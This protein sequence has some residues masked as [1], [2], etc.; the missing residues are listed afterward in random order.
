MSRSIALWVCLAALLLPPMAAGA[1]G[2]EDEAGGWKVIAG[3][4][5]YADSD[6]IGSNETPECYGDTMLACGMWY[7]P[8]T[9]ARAGQ[10]R[11]YTLCEDYE[12]FRDEFY[13]GELF[14]DGLTSDPRSRYEWVFY[15][16]DIWTLSEADIRWPGGWPYKTWRPGDTAVD[17]RASTCYDQPGVSRCLDAR[18]ADPGWEPRDGCPT[19]I[20]QGPAFEPPH[21]SDDP[22]PSLIL[23][24]SSKGWRLVTLYQA[25]RLGSDASREWHP[26]H[27]KAK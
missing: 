14:R 12:F 6:C 2:T 25:S 10:H 5:S 24:R 21:F 13:P 8:R 16:R 7:H 26:D 18:E 1:G 4:G 23:R 3:D 22:N 27:W 15:H 11:L 9:A 19:G 17:I 20:C